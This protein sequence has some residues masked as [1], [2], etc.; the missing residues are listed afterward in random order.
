M[1]HPLPDTRVTHTVSMIAVG[2]KFHENGTLMKHGIKIIK[3]A[4]WKS[5]SLFYPSQFFFLFFFNSLC[6]ID[7]AQLRTWLLPGHTEHP[8]RPPGH[9]DTPSENTFWYISLADSFV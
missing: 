7:S 4:K 5:P 9:K 1:T 2:L 8:Y 6:Q 3:L